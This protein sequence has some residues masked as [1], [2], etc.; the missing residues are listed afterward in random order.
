MNICFHGCLNI[1]FIVLKNS[2]D[3]LKRIKVYY[4][5]NNRILLELSINTSVFPNIKTKQKKA[6]LN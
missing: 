1:Y 6:K 5:S 2:L 3:F 4:C